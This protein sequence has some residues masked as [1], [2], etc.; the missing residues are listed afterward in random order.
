V[1]T[2]GWAYLALGALVAVMAGGY[3][4]ASY[5]N[6]GSTMLVLAGA[7]AVVIGGYLV[8]VA[9]GAGGPSDEKGTEEPY[10]PHASIWPF[11]TGLSCLILANGLALGLWGLI[12]GAIGLALSLTGYARQSRLRT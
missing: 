10:L 8:G 11:W 4:L 12:P 2:L 5:E 3:W 9:R 1:T 6:A 7:L